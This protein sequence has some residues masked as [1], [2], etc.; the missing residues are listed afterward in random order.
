[1]PP[2]NCDPALTAPNPSPE[3]QKCPKCGAE[4]EPIDSGAEGP[5]FRQLQLCPGCYLVMWSDQDGLHV[6]QGVPVKPGVD[7][8]G[9]PGWVAPEPEKC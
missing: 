3:D 5:P 4:M 7:P 2:N 9:D 8:R 1:M 6:R